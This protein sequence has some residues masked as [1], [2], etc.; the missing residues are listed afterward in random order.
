LPPASPAP[1]SLAH[2]VGEREAVT[3]IVHGYV[4]RDRSAN[5]RRFEC[6]RRSI[7]SV[8]CI[9]AYCNAVSNLAHAWATPRSAE[10]IPGNVAQPPFSM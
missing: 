5:E 2:D 4:W 7:L 9:N 8:F 10:V 3:D 1:T 6:R